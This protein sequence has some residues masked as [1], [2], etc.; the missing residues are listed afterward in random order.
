[1]PLLIPPIVSLAISLLE[2]PKTTHKNLEKYNG[3]DIEDGA[4]TMRG[5]IRN[6]FIIRV[7]LADERH[8]TARHRVSDLTLDEESSCSTAI[9][10][11]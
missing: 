10:Q 4:E 2:G 7:Y 9:L 5:E 1:M 3:C 11:H 6:H 8:S